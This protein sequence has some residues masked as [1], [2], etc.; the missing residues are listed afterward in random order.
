MNTIKIIFHLST[1]MC[2]MDS[3]EVWEY[4]DD[5]THEELDNEAWQL[6]VQNAES[7]GY[8]PEEWRDEMD[9]D[10]LE[11]EDR[12]TSVEGWWELYDETKHSGLV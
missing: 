7:Y 9:T 4:D 2:G 3:H 5:V 10:D 11:D 12:F 8:Y 1:G 6:A